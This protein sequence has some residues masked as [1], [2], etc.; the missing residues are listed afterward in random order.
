MI[1]TLLK[2]LF[3][4]WLTIKRWNNFPRIEDV[5]PLDN[6]GFVIHVALFLAHLEE[7]EWKIV[8][9]EFI[10]KK[11][12]FEL[13]NSLIL[14]DINSGTRDY[15]SQIDPK[16]I[17][18]LEKKVQTFLFWFEWWDFIKE[19]MKNILENDSKIL[20]NKIIYVSKKFAGYQ[21]ASINSRVFFN[22]Y[23]VPL[24]QIKEI[25]EKERKQLKSLDYLLDS[26]NY[27]K[28]L[29]HIRRL[30]HSMRWA[31][32][33]RNYP[34]SVMSHLAI[35]TFISYILWNLENQKWGKIDIL[36]LMLRS[37]YHDIPE[38][39]TWDII[40]P[41]K[42]AIEGFEEILEKVEYKMMDDYF[43]IYISKEYKNEISKFMLDPF[44]WKQGQLAKQ[45]DLISALLESRIER[46]SWNT[47]F[48]DIYKNIKQ[49]L[50]NSKN[51]S[52]N[53]FLKNILI[54]FWEEIWD[55][56]LR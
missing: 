3:S 33:Q 39:I 29:L 47:D 32:K 27:K 34:I 16:I 51:H 43:F 49:N 42:K 7:K 17:G 31:G 56:N 45:A 13:F 50:N 46:D 22:T 10:I 38:F 54:D 20:E 36:D 37:I 26:E 52:T 30:S 9:K 48:T 2:L 5:T 18:K 4:K 14:A 15:I 12:I 28:Y 55:F 21:E 11:I 53:L 35:I 6:T 40:T 41:T 8:D 44:S 1:W 25:L 24:N 23:D 19:D